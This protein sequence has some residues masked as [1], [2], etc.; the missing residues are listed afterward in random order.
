MT[1]A[2]SHRLLELG[3]KPLACVQSGGPPQTPKSLPGMTLEIQ[4]VAPWR[5][6][7]EQAGLHHRYEREQTDLGDWLRDLSPDYLLVACWPRLLPP[8]WLRSA[9]IDAFNIHP[10]LL[11]RYRGIDPI[12]AMLNKGDRDYGVS[13]HRMT[14]HYDA[15]EVVAQQ[16]FRLVG[17]P[18]RLRIETTAARIGAELFA[19]RMP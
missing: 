17:P 13:L 11:P 12:G 14:Q 16:A 18:G 2:V 7:L 8:A 1:R 10:S 5:Q 3:L 9:R 6:D 19:A 4:P 15:G